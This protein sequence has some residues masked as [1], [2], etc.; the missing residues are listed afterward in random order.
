MQAKY[1]SLSHGKIKKLWIY[2]NT[3]KT[4]AS[5]ILD[6]KMCNAWVYFAPLAMLLQSHYYLDFFCEE[7]SMVSILHLFF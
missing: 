2:L 3:I 7:S 1:T 5:I 4:L 6:R